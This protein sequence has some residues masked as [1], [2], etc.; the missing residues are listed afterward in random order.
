MSNRPSANRFMFR[1][2]VR[3][4]LFANRGRLFVVLL[5]LSAG[6]AV[7]AALLNLQTDAKRRLTT[8]FRAFGPNVVISPREPNSDSN[9]LSESLYDQIPDHNEA[10]EI[11]KAAFL[12]GLVDIEN[13][14]EPGKQ[15][16]AVVVGYVHWYIHPE[17]VISATLMQY[18][19]KSNYLSS[20][21]HCAVGQRL[22]S[23][24]GLKDG[25]AIKIT[26]GGT[27]DYDSI[28]VLPV[29]GGPE[30]NQIFVGLDKAQSLLARP[31]SVSL[32]QISAPGNPQQIQQLMDKLQAAFPDATGRPLRQFTEAQAK[33]YSRISGLLTAATA[34][35]LILTA[36]CVMAAMTNIAAERKHDVGM[37]KAIGGSA[38]GILNLFLTE[39]VLLG[40]IGGL[41]GAAAG[42]ALSMALGKAVF[43]VAALPRLI[44]YPI[45]VTLTIIVAILG[46]YPLRRL[47]NVRPA[48]IFR[49]EV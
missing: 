25:D 36:L 44:V 17:R 28:F 10:G 19:Q 46:A 35:I 12:Y 34:I 24:L 48:T 1:R 39:A 15:V 20:N 37:M 7:S 3:R 14:A 33:I 2:L 43:G 13:S 5:A 18:E 4:L 31:K 16:N 26:G 22:A 45:S 8:E 47:A 6:A 21:M 9:L 40:L 27:P 41:I 23:A 30:D 32:I 29:T 38:R 49:G 11:G 42:I